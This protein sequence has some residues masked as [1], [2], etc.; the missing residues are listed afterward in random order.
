MASHYI[1]LAMADFL[2][3][4]TGETNIGMKTIAK[5]CWCNEQTIR[6][7]I[8][9]L[10]DL[11]VLADVGYG[12]GG[13]R[14]LKVVGY[15]EYVQAIE[16][17]GTFKRPVQKQ[18]LDEKNRCVENPRRV[19]N[20]RQSSYS[21]S[22]EGYNNASE[23]NNIYNNTPS[24]TLPQDT[25]DG[26]AW[27]APPPP[28]QRSG[29]GVSNVVGMARPEPAKRT[30]G[31]AAR[32]V[33]AASESTANWIKVWRLSDETNF[34]AWC[35]WMEANSYLQVQSAYTRGFVFVPTAKVEDGTERFIRKFPLANPAQMSNSSLSA[36]GS[37]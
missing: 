12:P 22:M 19:E 18:C 5:A 13:T 21:Y 20:P 8:K 17:G 7:H 25:A 28:R 23:K 4:E 10:I 27:E 32:Q 29:S 11:D 33:T 24:L 9:K 2:D 14:I 37:T 34:N 31:D 30:A 16:G 26:A 35:Q 1:L 15:E 3:W 36:N 6:A